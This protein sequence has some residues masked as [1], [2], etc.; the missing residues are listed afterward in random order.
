MYTLLSFYTNNWQYPK[1]AKFLRRNCKNFNIKYII[2]ELPDQGD[3]IANTRMKTKFV[4][5]K[6]MELKSPVLW[7]DVD[8]TLLRKPHVDLSY[9]IGA[10]RKPPNQ[11]RTFYVSPLFFNYTPKGIEFVKRWYECDAE[12]SDHL[13]FEHVWQEGFDGKMLEFPNYYCDIKTTGKTVIRL[14]LSKDPSKQEYFR[15]LNRS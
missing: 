2:E 13:A 7:V 8:S 9:D 10:V 12:G 1:Y 4:H 11:L 14:G 6:L 3:W 15:D 5:D